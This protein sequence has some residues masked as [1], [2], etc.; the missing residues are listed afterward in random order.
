MLSSSHHK[1]HR[2]MATGKMYNPPCA[3]PGLLYK[4][5]STSE[6]NRNLSPKVICLT[7]ISSRQCGWD[8]VDSAALNLYILRVFLRHIRWT[9]ALCMLTL[10]SRLTL[11]MYKRQWLRRHA[12]SLFEE[13]AWGKSQTRDQFS[14][15]VRL[16]YS[17]GYYRWNW[18]LA[19]AYY[20]S[21]TCRLLISH[22]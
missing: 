5:R 21:D 8:D 10:V 15:A 12:K 14:V 7:Q 11:P 19:A 4:Q 18:S 6:L 3:L 1:L 17:S 22:V 2:L 9:R 20:R 13:F 16:T